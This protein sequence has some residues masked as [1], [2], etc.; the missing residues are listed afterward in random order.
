MAYA[1]FATRSFDGESQL[2]I[3]SNGS[4]GPGKGSGKR[5]ESVSIS[6]RRIQ[7]ENKRKIKRILALRY[8]TG[9]RNRD[10]RRLTTPFVSFVTEG[11]RSQCD[12]LVSDLPCRQVARQP[13]SRFEGGPVNENREYIRSTSAISEEPPSVAFITANRKKKVDA[14]TSLS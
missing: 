4:S 8:E 12:S 10:R 6:S 3:R 2:E 14:L 7:R 5:D 9:V 13:A 11:H 1:T